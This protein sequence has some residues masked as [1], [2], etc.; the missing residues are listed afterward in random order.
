MLRLAPA[1]TVALLLGP[2][3]AGLAA[4]LLPAF[5]FPPSAGPAPSLEPWSQLWRAPGLT[6]ALALT[7]WTGVASTALS[8]ALALSFCAVVSGS[9]AFARMRHGLAPLLAAPHAAMAIGFAFLIAPSGWIARLVSPGLTGWTVPP[10]LVTDRDPLG[11]A[12]ILGLAVKETPFLVLM[13]LA[14]AAQWPEQALLRAA[15]ALGYRPA[16]AWFTAMAPLLWRS[17]RLPVFAVLAFSLSVVDM[18]IV[19]APGSP[20]PLAVLATRWFGGYDFAQYGAAAAASVLLATLVVLGLALAQAFGPLA[21]RCVTGW[22][23]AGRRGGPLDAVLHA[24]AMAAVVLGLAGLASMAGMALWSVAEVWRFPEAWPAA[25]SLEPWR[26][27]APALGRPLAVTLAVAAL[28]T[29]AALVLALACLENERRRG[30]KPGEGALLLVYA[31]LLVPQ[32]AFLFGWQM[33]LVR[34]A[35]DGTLLAVAATHAVFVLP[36]VFLALADPYRALD[37]RYAR[38]AA[39]L[40]A[41]PAG[42]FWRVTL[43][44]LARPLATA[45]AVGIAVS[46]AQYLPTLFAGGGRLPTLTTEAVTL[47]SGGDRRVLGVYALLQSAIPLVAYGL[48]LIAP[49]RTAGSAR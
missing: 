35:A 47:S 17:L 49:R 5:G 38:V 37:P 9:R 27:A 34:L 3:V 25:L 30:L 24:G 8:L 46:M 11:L 43:P 32:I 19:L 33:V 16:R 40:G 28:S 31:P 26:R 21:R 6:T 23:W 13:I 4:T 10:S 39:G 45:A 18:A 12:L 1:L 2:L 36:Y 15:R 44:L 29:A 48:A 20:P 7:L 14:A 22:V 41:S 42:V